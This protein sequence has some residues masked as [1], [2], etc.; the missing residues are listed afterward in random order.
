[1]V[2]AEELKSKIHEIERA[3]LQAE[4][5]YK[6][7]R[8]F[9]DDM[10]VGELERILESHLPSEDITVGEAIREAVSIKA[11]IQQQMAQ[12]FRDIKR[13]YPGEYFKIVEPV[14]DPGISR[15]M[16]L[17]VRQL[18]SGHY[19]AFMEKLPKILE[20]IGRTDPD[21]LSELRSVLEE[22]TKPP[23]K[24]YE[25][26]K[27]LMESDDFRRLLAIFGLAYYPP[28]PNA[29]PLEEIKATLE[30]SEHFLDQAERVISILSIFKSRDKVLRIKERLIANLPA[31]KAMTV[32]EAR[33][34]IESR[35][36]PDLLRERDTLVAEMF[37]KYPEEA[38]KLRYLKRPEKIVKRVAPKSWKQVM[39]LLRHYGEMPLEKL[40]GEAEA[41]YRMPADEVEK[42]VN[43]MIKKG[44]IIKKDNILSLTY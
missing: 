16:S 4:Q 5:L 14:R 15:F 13:Y 6:V 17:T 32:G 10:T 36:I 8:M 34:A 11:N 21:I 31:N 30:N 33:D 25:E 43:E 40:K 22:V 1:M 9:P 3:I 24:K 7:L 23:E 18:K 35:I 38:M 37:E 27:K 41:V 39:A 19:K 42:A 29:P 44:Y 12:A 2:N 20:N 26:W 28:P